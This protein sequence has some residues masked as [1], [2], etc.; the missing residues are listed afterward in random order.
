MRLYRCDN[1]GAVN[2][3]EETIGALLSGE[4]PQKTW[5]Q[6]E[7]A[8]QFALV[9]Q[10]DLQ[11]LCY[12]CMWA[13]IRVMMEKYGP[14]PLGTS[15]ERPEQ[16]EDVLSLRLGD[17]VFKAGRYLHSWQWHN[18]DEYSHEGPVEN[19]RFSICRDRRGSGETGGQEGQAVRGA[20]GEVPEE[21]A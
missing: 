7:F 8:I 15:P 13:E 14:T 16:S 4:T 12:G 18:G 2:T 21:G 20:S 6:P 1:C 3:A 9:F 11:H 5:S 19:C 10:T 17:A